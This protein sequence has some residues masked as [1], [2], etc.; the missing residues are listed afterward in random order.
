MRILFITH[1]LPY[2]PNLGGYIRTYNFIRCLSISHKMDLIC[3]LFK[4]E[5]QKYVK[6]MET[7]C[8]NVYTIPLRRKSI[9]PYLLISLFSSR[10]FWHFRDF[11]KKM[12]KLITDQI[13]K[14]DY[15]I[16]FEEQLSM[17]GYVPPKTNKAYRIYANILIGETIMDRFT[18]NQKNPLKKILGRIEATKLRKLEK[19]ACKNVDLTITISEEEKRIIESWGVPPDKII[20]ITMGVD[21]DRFKPLPIKHNS[22]NIINLGLARFP[23]NVDGMLYFYHEIYPEIKKASPNTHLYIVG[24]EPSKKIR[25]LEQDKSVTVTGFVGDLDSFLIDTGVFVVPLRIGGG[26]KVRLLNALAM[27]LPV[28]ATSVGVEGIDLTHGKEVLIANSPKEFADAVI[29]I[30]ENPELKKNLSKNGPSLI[31]KKYT[32]N[33]V[34]NQIEKLFNE[35]ESKINEKNHI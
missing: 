19:D 2:P 4:D 20:S 14:N 10:P 23:P 8:N 24:A 12:K 11:S 5:D 31:R 33:T 29:E 21:T 26:V 6:N 34:F 27:G 32:W 9:F 7:I 17:V 3:Y 1:L 13:L 15:D 25:K 28:V 30:L 18:K 22:Y 35:I 16:I